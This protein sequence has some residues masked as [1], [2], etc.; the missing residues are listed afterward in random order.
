MRPPFPEVLI[1]IPLLRRLGSAKKI[2]FFRKNHVIFS[3][4]DRSGSIFYIQKGSAKLTV[5]SKQGKKAIIVILDGES[6]FGENALASNRP[7]TQLMPLLS[8][9]SGP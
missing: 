7:H 8:P 2:V 3:H 5:T 1:L 6:F 4:G 9:T